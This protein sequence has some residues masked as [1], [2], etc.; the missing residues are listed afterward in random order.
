MKSSL[1]AGVRGATLRRRQH[2]SFLAESW[3]TALSCSRSVRLG[4]KNARS[5]TSAPVGISAPPGPALDLYVVAGRGKYKLPMSSK[6]EAKARVR[7]RRILRYLPMPHSSTTH[8]VNAG[9][10]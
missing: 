9:A 2:A 4:Y 1:G 8:L 10:W 3:P 6:N 7:K 5:V